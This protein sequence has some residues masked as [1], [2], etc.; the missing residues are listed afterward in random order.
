MDF[1]LQV[2]T[3]KIIYNNTNDIELLYD[4]Y[5]KIKQLK[6]KYS[7]IIKYNIKE[8]IANHEYLYRIKILSRLMIDIRKK[9]ELIANDENLLY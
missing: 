5:N 4:V 7:I 3:W 1:Q 2:N 6:D 8:I 9:Y